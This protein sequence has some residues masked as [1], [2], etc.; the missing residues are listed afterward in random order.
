MSNGSMTA[1][2]FPKHFPK[3]MST[4][5]IPRAGQICHYQTLEPCRPSRPSMNATILHHIHPSTWP[6]LK[7]RQTKATSSLHS[8]IATTSFSLALKCIT[9]QY[10]LPACGYWCCPKVSQP[11][12]FP[13]VMQKTHKICCQAMSKIGIE[14]AS[15]Q[16]GYPQPGA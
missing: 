14:P 4:C 10:T 15:S 3:L 5:R 8:I 6:S 9:L 16:R 7:C 1:K 12:I 2:S 11:I 13:S